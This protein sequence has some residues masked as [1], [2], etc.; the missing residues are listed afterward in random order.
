MSSVTDQMASA[1]P[2][3]FDINANANIGATQTTSN[4]ANMVDAFKQ[5]LKEV[6][7]VL[8]DEVAGRFVTDTVE[9]VVY[10]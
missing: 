2:T 7:I 10:S 4:F 6:N 5:A 9:R 1:V 8:D 3:N